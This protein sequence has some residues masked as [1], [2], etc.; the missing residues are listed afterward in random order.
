MAQYQAPQDPRKTPARRQRHSRERSHDA[1]LPQPIPWFWLGMGGVVTLVAVAT[2]VMLAHTILLRPPLL[3]DSAQAPVIIHLTAPPSPTPSATPPFPT[4]TII[5]T[6]TPVPTPDVARA[7]DEVTVGYYA[8]VQ[9]TGEFGVTVRGGPSTSNAAIT[10]APEGTLLYVIGG[11]QADTTVE[12]LWWQ[13]RLEGGGEGW[14]AGEFL[15]PAAA[16]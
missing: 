6:F 2:A 1:D 12:R 11:P 8:S 16:P 14:V 3:A 15:A 5:P 13:I 9:G 7:P 4:P 10:V